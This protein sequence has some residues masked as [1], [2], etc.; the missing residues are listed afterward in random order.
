MSKRFF[1]KGYSLGKYAV[2]TSCFSIVDTGR[3]EVLGE[4]SGDRKI[5]V[6][7]YYPVDKSDVAG[8]E[9]A[10]VFS[11]KKKEPGLQSSKSPDDFS[12]LLQ[13]QAVCICPDS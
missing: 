10:S 5:A 3:K 9:Y 12:G 8:R 7:M 6:R 11:E 4:G 2:G 13:D 1:P